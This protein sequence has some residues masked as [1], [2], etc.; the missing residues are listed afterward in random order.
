MPVRGYYTYA[1]DAVEGIRVGRLNAG[2]NTTFVVYRLGSTLIDCG[3]SNQWGYVRPFISE[4]PVRQLLITHHHEDHSGNARRISALTGVTPL[5]PEQSKGKMATGYRIPPVQKV[6]W[7]SMEP[8]TT[9]PYP[10]FI[11]LEDGSP[12]IPVHTPGHAKDL[13]VFYLPRQKWLFSGDLYVSKTIRILRGDENLELLMDSI[14]RVLELDFDVIFCPHRGIVEYARESMEEKL[15]NLENLC[16]E[17]Q[18]LA[19]KGF[20]LNQV[21]RE[22]LGREEMISWISAFNLSKRN[23]IRA[24]LSVNMDVPDK[25]LSGSG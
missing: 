16:Y 24:A 14:R 17:A 22:V 6:V 8:V 15:K 13:H 2:I 18:S 4:K 10:E 12:V 9:E 20:S 23:L 19:E 3:P 21:T 5:A 1:N 11:E 7:G 25:S